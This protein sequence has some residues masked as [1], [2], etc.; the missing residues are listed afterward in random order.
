MTPLEL[1]ST[2]PKRERAPLP[3]S[4]IDFALTAQI[5]VAWAGEGGEE[6]RLGWWRS[7]LV[8]E[9]GGE[10]LFRRLLPHTWEWALLQA[11]REAARRKDAE[12][13]SKDHDPDQI[14]SLFSLGFE[15]DERLE[16]RLGD[17]KRS[18]ASPRDALPRLHHGIQPTW[19]RDAFFDWVAGHGTADTTATPAGRLLKG[20]APTSLETTV[21]Q[22][23]AALA[24]PSAA[25]PV[26][27]FRRA[28]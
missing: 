26:P 9:F 12:L 27:H 16:E 8:S 4:E 17:L 22:L 24:P 20:P 11:V 14:L 1:D 7:D 3:L 10:D 18:G 21:R 15:L 6:P 13:R 23:V 19:D 2:P 25:Y 28:R 5:V